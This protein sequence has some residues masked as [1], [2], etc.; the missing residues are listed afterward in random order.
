[1]AD[2]RRTGSPEAVQRMMLAMMDMV[3]LDLAVLE[4]AFAGQ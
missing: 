4:A 2:M 1:M 3:K